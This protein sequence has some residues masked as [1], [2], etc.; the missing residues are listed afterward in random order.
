MT[1]AVTPSHVLVSLPFV[2]SHC[3]MIRVYRGAVAAFD[4]ETGERVWTAPVPQ[5]TGD[6]AAF[7]RAWTV[8]ERVIFATHGAAVAL[9]ETG[10]RLWRLNADAGPEACR[11]GP[12]SPF[13]EGFSKRGRWLRWSGRDSGTCSLDLVRGRIRHS[14]RSP[15]AM[16]RPR[17]RF[18]TQ[19]QHTLGLTCGFAGE[20]YRA[21]ARC[22]DERDCKI[23]IQRTR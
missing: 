23:V 22:K 5:T 9:D 3:S 16:D 4:K 18:S 13:V 17:C 6:Q 12:M 21:V 2:P 7:L 20:R 8:G 10:H 15:P 19:P 14:K 11:H 1:L